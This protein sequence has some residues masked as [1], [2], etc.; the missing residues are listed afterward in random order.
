MNDDDD[1]DDDSDDYDDDD[2]DDDDDH[3]NDDDALWQT[4]LHPTDLSI[5]SNFA[6]A[7]RDNL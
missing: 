7:W 6:G 2:G 5:S 3:D 4:F 1:D